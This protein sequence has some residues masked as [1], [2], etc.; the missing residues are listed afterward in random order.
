MASLSFGA[1]A[2]D[3]SELFSQQQPIDKISSFFIAAIWV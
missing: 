3:M 1:D 2:I